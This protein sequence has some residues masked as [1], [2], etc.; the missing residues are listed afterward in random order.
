MKR[1]DRAAVD[2][3]DAASVRRVHIIDACP[4]SDLPVS[5]KYERN[6]GNGEHVR[7]IRDGVSFEVLFRRVD[8]TVNKRQPGS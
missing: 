4:A 6:L 5:Y 3:T 8:Q 2:G 1:F 7:N